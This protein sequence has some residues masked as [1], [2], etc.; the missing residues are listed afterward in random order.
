M[1]KKKILEI[2]TFNECSSGQNRS[3]VWYLAK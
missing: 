1:G 2:E 3:I